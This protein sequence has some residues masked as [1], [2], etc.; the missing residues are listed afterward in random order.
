[1]IAR[2]WRCRVPQ[3]R[4]GAAAAHIA[5]TGIAG[6]RQIAGYRGSQLL[7]RAVGPA[8]CELVLVTYW[9]SADAVRQ[10]AGRDISRAVLYPGD[11][12]CGIQADGT[13]THSEVVYSDQPGTGGGT[14]GGR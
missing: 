11:A 8:G 5:S 12:D 9:E 14:D 6:C 10:F 4:A 3:D 13:V 7:R 1:M 2:I